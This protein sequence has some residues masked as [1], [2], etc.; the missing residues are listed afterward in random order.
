[1]VRPTSPPMQQPAAEQVTHYNNIYTW[2]YINY[3]SSQGH[4]H[5][6]SCIRSHE[7]S[8]LRTSANSLS[9]SS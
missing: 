8:H 1:M 7:L 9:G 3:K 6:T 2:I 5:P 4:C